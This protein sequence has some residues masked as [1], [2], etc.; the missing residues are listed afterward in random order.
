MF[1]LFGR[2]AGN[3]M[4]RMAV[5]KDFNPQIGLIQERSRSSFISRVANKNGSGEALLP[6]RSPWWS[7]Y[8]ED[9]KVLPKDCGKICLR[10]LWVLLPPP[11]PWVAKKPSRWSGKSC[12]SIDPPPP[13]VDCQKPGKVTGS[14]H[15]GRNGKWRQNPCSCSVLQ[16]KWSLGTSKST[17]HCPNSSISS[18]CLGLP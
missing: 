3:A 5:G 2:L 14:D 4:G 13:P 10:R 9:V 16:G 17:G 12:R 6:C 18:Y 1:V 7:V 8:F 15:L 11:P